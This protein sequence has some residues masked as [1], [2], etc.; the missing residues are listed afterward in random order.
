MKLIELFE[1]TELKSDKFRGHNYE[2]YYSFEFD[3]KR[4]KELKILEIGINYGYSINLWSRFFMN[5]KIIGVDIQNMYGNLL[6]GLP[7]IELY[8]E[9]AYSETFSNK[10]ENEY[11]DYI[12][13]DGSHTLSHQLKAIELFYPKLKIGGKLIIEDIQ[14]IGYFKQIIEHC[15][16]EELSYVPFDLRGR[17]DD[18]I[19][20][21]TKK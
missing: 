8:I 5:S 2:K 19:I 9:N 20:E 6:N 3:N 4:L 21:I 15:K 10:F 1:Q 7:N 12:I 14:G 17:A 18:L 16:K 13:E 11:F